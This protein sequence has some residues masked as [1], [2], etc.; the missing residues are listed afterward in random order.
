[1][2]RGKAYLGGANR[3]VDAVLGGWQLAGLNRWTSGLPFSFNEPGW[4]TD[5]Q[6][7]GY[8]V[9]T[10]PIKTRKHLVGGLPQLFDDPAAIANGFPHGNPM[11]APYPGEAGQRN[12][13]R[14]DG[15]FDIDSSL[16]KTWLLTEGAKLKFA[17]EVYNATN[18]T[19][20]DVSPASL[21][22]GLGN[23]AFAIGYYAATLSTYRRMQFGLRLDF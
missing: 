8:G 20:F 5:W 10:A 4:S 19:R 21:N 23:G 6:I 15:Y 14:G 17:W 9:K 1:V 3:L 2:G 13:F 12:G 22:A 7:E 11:R 16:S 18:S